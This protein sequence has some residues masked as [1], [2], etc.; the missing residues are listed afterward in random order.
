M[1]VGLDARYH[2]GIASEVPIQ[3]RNAANTM[4]VCGGEA[5]VCLL[6]ADEERA[7]TTLD[8]QAPPFLQT[9]SHFAKTSTSN[10]HVGSLTN[11]HISCIASRSP[12]GSMELANAPEELTKGLDAL[13]LERAGWVS[14]THQS[15]TDVLEGHKRP[16]DPVSAAK[17]LEDLIELA[18]SI[19]ETRK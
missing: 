5:L 17:T 18:S 6:G 3:A 10:L 7:N 8:F 12:S 19:S 9:P 2:L 14:N 4:R 13:Y 15:G 11:Q 16:D 1:C